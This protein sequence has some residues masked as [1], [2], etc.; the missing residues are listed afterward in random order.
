EPSGWLVGLSR[1]LR[2]GPPL[3]G[4]GYLVTRAGDWPF[5]L[6]VAAF[7]A[8][9]FLA[10]AFFAGAFFGAAFFAAAFFLAAIFLLLSDGSVSSPGGNH[11][12]FAPKS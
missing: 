10:A 4:L 12:F 9:A 3:A 5:V 2:Y 6:F 11:E 7:F 1:T 8:G